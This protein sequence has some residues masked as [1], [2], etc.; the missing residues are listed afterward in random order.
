MT[1][2]LKKPYTTYGNTIKTSKKTTIANEL[3]KTWIPT[4]KEFTKKQF[5][6]EI[7]TYLDL[8]GVYYLGVVRNAR[9]RA[10]GTTMVGAVQKFVLIKTH[11]VRLFIHLILFLV[12]P[13][14]YL[15]LTILFKLRSNSMKL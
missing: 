13:K 3:N 12:N 7:S 8:E 4:C 5:W 10:N 11:R 2:S 9:Q 1:Q 14:K 6:Y 15:Y